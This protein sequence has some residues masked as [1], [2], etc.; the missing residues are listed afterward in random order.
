M[1]AAPTSTTTPAELPGPTDGVLRPHDGEPDRRDA[2]LPAPD[3]QNHAANLMELPGGDLAC[4]WFAGTQEGVPDIG[5]R[6][7]RLP[8]GGERWTDPVTLSDDGARSEQNPLLFVAPSG[9]VWLLWTAQIAGNQDT[10]EVRVR[11][12]GDAGVTWSAQRT[13]F[14]AGPA[15]GVFV[16][17]PVVVTSTGRW[18]LPI[19]HCVTPPEGRWVGDLDTSAVMVSDDD[20]ATWREVAVPDSTGQVHMN[21]V[22]RPD[23]TLAAFYRSRRADA[24]H[25]S[26]STDDGESWSVPEPVELPNNNSSV[27]VVGLPDGRL[28]LV[29]NPSSRADAT[30]RRASL[31]DEI[32]DSGSVGDAGSADALRE[33]AFW[34]APRAPMTLA[35]SDDGG[36]TWPVR[37]DLE[38]G[39]G[40]C[41]VNDS[42]GKRNR[43]FSYPSIRAGADGGLHIA[44]TYYRQAI[45]YVHLAAPDA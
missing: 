23:G 45:R 17:Q 13:L 26:V 40:F 30:D 32:S 10:A 14:P 21:V 44:Y 27:Q 18:L 35:I 3:V 12:S 11:T 22:A 25:R 43:E 28:A 36:A 4:V 19:W 38:T 8:A 16:R 1:S 42:R 34:G 5:V 37:R 24:V 29:G 2:L 31:Y 41:L 15:G 6:F 33:G 39:D 9:T 7:S 20:G